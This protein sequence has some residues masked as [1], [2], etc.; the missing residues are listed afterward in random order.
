MKFTITILLAFI[1]SASMAQSKTND[2]TAFRTLWAGNPVRIATIDFNK[3]DTISAT[4]LV[5]SNAG[6]N[7]AYIRVFFGYIVIKKY[8]SI[9]MPIAGKNHYMNPIEF[10][11]KNKKHFTFP[12][13]Y[14]IE[15]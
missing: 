6:N 1:V 3:L 4:L 15:D 10:I 7:E 13:I 8:G 2:S 11:D 12:V 9:V 14:W 5:P